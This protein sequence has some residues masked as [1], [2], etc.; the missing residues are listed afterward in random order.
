[1]SLDLPNLPFPTLIAMG[2]RGKKWKNFHCLKLGK[3][4]PS[5]IEGVSESPNLKSDSFY[6][7]R[8]SRYGNFPLTC[9]GPAPAL[10]FPMGRFVPNLAHTITTPSPTPRYPSLAK[11]FA[12]LLYDQPFRSY[13]PF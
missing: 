6:L 9:P 2:P 12:I 1:M 13:G 10:P 4:G 3:E 8:F 7:D 11:I 5:L